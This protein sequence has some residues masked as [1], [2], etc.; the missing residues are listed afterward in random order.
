MRETKQLSSDTHKPQAFQ[1]NDL[2]G[3][4][5]WNCKKPDN[6]ITDLKNYTKKVLDMSISFCFVEIIMRTWTAIVL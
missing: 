5:T 3:Y 4:T 1:R 2:C 6:T